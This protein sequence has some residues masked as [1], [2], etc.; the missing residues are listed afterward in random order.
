MFLCKYA[1]LIFDFIDDK[2]AKKRS[3]FYFEL[4]FAYFFHKRGFPKSIGSFP[5]NVPI[6]YNGKHFHKNFQNSLSVRNSF[7]S[8]Q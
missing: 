1:S 2:K 6:F 8:S 5:K 7:V 4:N 3:N